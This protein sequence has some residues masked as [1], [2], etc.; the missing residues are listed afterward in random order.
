[1]AGREFKD[2]VDAVVEKLVKKLEE[3]V[4]LEVMPDQADKMFLKGLHSRQARKYVKKATLVTH[5]DDFD[6]ED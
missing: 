1:M 3:K 4:F 6:Y 2:N 5:Q